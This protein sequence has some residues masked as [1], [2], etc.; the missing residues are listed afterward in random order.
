MVGWLKSIS[1]SV[2]GPLAKLGGLTTGCV[3]VCGS[4]SQPVQD[5][6]GRLFLRILYYFFFFEN[7]V[8]KN[9]CL[10]GVVL[11]KEARDVRVLKQ[12][13]RCCEL[14]VGAGEHTQ[15]L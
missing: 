14:L 8:K 10:C 1:L 6:R 9:L 5:D 15:V 7:L 4:Y 13:P 11:L 3:C 2:A 12:G